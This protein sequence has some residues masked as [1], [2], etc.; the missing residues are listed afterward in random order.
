MNQILRKREKKQQR[1]KLKTVT[2]EQQRNREEEFGFLD[3]E[4]KKIHVF[5]NT[6]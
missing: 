6:D 2:S 5:Y 4:V 1:P 3:Q